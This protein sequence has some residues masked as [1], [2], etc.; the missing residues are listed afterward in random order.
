MLGLKV[1]NI[2][3]IA[4][5]SSVGLTFTSCGYGLEMALLLR[6]SVGLPER[7][8]TTSENAGVAAPLLF[9]LDGE[10]GEVAF[11]DLTDCDGDATLG[12]S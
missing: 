3:L 11:P 9:G 4:G 2:D 5:S 1:G 7:A 8:E 12:L 6:T 10:I